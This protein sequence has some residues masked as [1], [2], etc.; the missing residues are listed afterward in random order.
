MLLGYFRLPHMMAF[1]AH[2]KCV[3]SHYSESNVVTFIL[4]KFSWV[5]KTYFPSTWNVFSASF[6][7]RLFLY[8]WNS[9]YSYFT[10]KTGITDSI[11]PTEF[12]K[13]YSFG[14]ENINAVWST[15]AC[16]ITGTVVPFYHMHSVLGIWYSV[17]YYIKGPTVVNKLCCFFFL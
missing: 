10:K 16:V 17:V 13:S 1:M 7:D 2:L 4:A 12:Q 11:T 6:A 8:L 9:I 14:K 15:S 5:L 3:V